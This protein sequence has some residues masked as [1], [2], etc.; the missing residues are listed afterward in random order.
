MNAAN[1]KGLSLLKFAAS[2]VTVFMMTTL[3]AHDQEASDQSK[4]EKISV[5]LQ[6]GMPREKV[7]KL[8]TETLAIENNYSPYGNNLRGGVVEYKD[9]QWI[10]EVTYNPGSPA[11]WVINKQGVAEHYPPVDE[12]VKSFRLYKFK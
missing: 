1:H 9:K 8:V 12:T 11:P 6:V 7:E 3:Y 10:L 2:I 4:L 5:L